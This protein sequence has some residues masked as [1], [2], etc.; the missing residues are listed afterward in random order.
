[1]SR[2]TGRRPRHPP[3]PDLPTM[4]WTRT[5]PGARPALTPPASRP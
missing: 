3:R 2:L 1:M 4:S 5:L